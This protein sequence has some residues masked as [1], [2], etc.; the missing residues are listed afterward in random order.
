MKTLH[1]R[2]HTLNTGGFVVAVGHNLAKNEGRRLNDV[3]ITISFRRVFHGPLIRTLQ[4]AWAFFEGFGSDFPILMPAVQG[5]GDDK[6]FGPDEMVTPEF[7][8]A[9]KTMPNLAA[10][11]KVFPAERVQKWQQAAGDAGRSMFEQVSDEEIAIG[12]F[13]SPTVELVVRDLVPEA[14]RLEGWDSMKEMDG[15]VIEQDDEGSHRVVEVIRA[16]RE[17]AAA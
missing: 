11:D 3:G 4:T 6:L 12:F 5:L 13:H 7:R 14:N 15:V 8:E 2:R 1:L 17:V 16:N 10:L 9:Q